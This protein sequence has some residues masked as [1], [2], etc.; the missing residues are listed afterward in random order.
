MQIENNCAKIKIK[1]RTEQS[2]AQFFGKSITFIE[3]H[4][5]DTILTQDLSTLL[6]YEKFT[7]IRKVLKLETLMFLKD[8]VRRNFT[9]GMI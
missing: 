3:T 1:E 6:A 7:K 5:T 9:L 8:E 4:V 2:L